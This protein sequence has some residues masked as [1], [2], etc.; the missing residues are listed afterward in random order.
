MNI[1]SVVLQRSAAW[2][3]GTKLVWLLQVRDIEIYN[4]V[5]PPYNINQATQELVL[6]ALEE[7]DQVN[8]RKS[9]VLMRADLGKKNSRC[10][11][12]GKSLPSD[13]NLF[14]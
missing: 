13:A 9:L 2:E 10:F 7:T 1:P 4:K 8:D 11:H 5:K 12:C 6:R 3:W 14:G